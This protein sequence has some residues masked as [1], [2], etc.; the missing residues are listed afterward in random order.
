MEGSGLDLV[1]RVAADALLCA[2]V[3][4]VAERMPAL[5]AFHRVHGD[6]RKRSALDVLLSLGVDFVLEEGRLL[7][8]DPVEAHHFWTAWLLKARQD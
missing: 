3:G 4:P 2:E 5:Q 7:V 1:H 6:A 8:L